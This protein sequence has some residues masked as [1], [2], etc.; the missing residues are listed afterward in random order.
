M[1]AELDV[2]I[3]SHGDGHWL[4]ACLRT[5]GERS[6][7]CDYRVIIVENGKDAEHPPAVEASG[8]EVLRV[9]NRGFAAANNEG[10]ARSTAERVLFLNPDTELQDGTL[11]QLCAALDS[12]PSVGL[13]AVRQIGSSGR[14][15]PS[16]RRFPT[17]ARALAQ[18][19]WSERWP[20]LGR[21]V[22]ERV[23]DSA[24]Y[25]RVGECDWTTGAVMLVRRST[26][27]TTGPFDERF[28]LYSEETDLCRRIKAAGW[29]ILYEPSIAFLHHAGKAGAEPRRES[30]MVYAR[31]Q[32]ARKHFRP[33][34]Y[35]IYRG[36]LMLGHVLRLPGLCLLGSTK[37]S[38]YE[39]SLACL[40]VLLGRAGSPFTAHTAGSG[41]A[42]SADEPYLIRS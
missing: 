21:S 29:Q 38:S 11:A 10:L 24:A 9:E 32:Y 23:L 30:Q 13:L 42:P 37:S 15:D 2:I 12:R 39:A 17:P 31:L 41:L 25:D 34:R 27:E 22:G 6:G 7:G 26:L 14:T 40:R 35:R 3:V 1:T 20:W 18:A 19:L 36:A 33:T 5:L 4:P 16:L 8:A 28:F